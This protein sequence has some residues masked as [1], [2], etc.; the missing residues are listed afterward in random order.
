MVRRR[1]VVPI[2]P[3]LVTVVVLLLI[4]E[5]L[6]LI[7]SAP[8]NTIS[9]VIWGLPPIGVFASGVLCGHFFWQRSK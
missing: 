7:D 4:I 3:L 1:W 5:T 2:K 9:E 6:T 8:H